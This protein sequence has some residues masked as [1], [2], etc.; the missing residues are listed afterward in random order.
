MN[1]GG[2]GLGKTWTSTGGGAPWAGSCWSD[3]TDRVF[4]GLGQWVDASSKAIH[5]QHE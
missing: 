4:A 5:L 2:D 3:D 1:G